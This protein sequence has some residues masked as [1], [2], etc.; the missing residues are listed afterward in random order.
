V[1]EVVEQ[2]ECPFRPQM[3]RQLLLERHRSDFAE[4]ERDRDSCGD[5]R[6]VPEPR[7][8]N[9]EHAVG[10]IA[11]QLQEHLHRETRLPDARRARE[12][13]ESYARLSQRDSQRYHVAVTA[14][15]RRGRNEQWL[16]LAVPRLCRQVGGWGQRAGGP[17]GAIIVRASPARYQLA[18]AAISGGYLCCVT[19]T[20]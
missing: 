14:E 3:A 6:R 18:V 15:E 20:C 5:S 2:E 9:E 12:R 13:N 1:L 7:E 17:H 19:P 11:L 8:G 10:E 4:P 16:T